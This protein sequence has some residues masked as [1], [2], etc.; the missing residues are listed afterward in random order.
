MDAEAILSSQNAASR[1]QIDEIVVD[2]GIDRIIKLIS[3][4]GTLA[5]FGCTCFL[6]F[7]SPM[8]SCYPIV[9]GAQRDIKVST[10]AK[11]HIE[12]VCWE[13]DA[14]ELETGLA[15]GT[16]PFHDSEFDARFLMDFFSFAAVDSACYSTD[17]D[18]LLECHMFGSNFRPREIHPDFDRTAS[19]RSGKSE[20]RAYFGE[21]SGPRKT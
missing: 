17:S 19:E 12:T 11:L 18:L 3:Q 20:N 14:Q 1:Q 9:N 15:V 4:A 21:S 5:V 8:I 6:T 7:G 10:A 2:F 16:T 13:L